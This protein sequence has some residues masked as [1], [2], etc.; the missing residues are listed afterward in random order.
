MKVCLALGGG[1][2][3]GYAH[4]GVLKG[5]FE[6]GITKF[7]AISGT[8]AGGMI[9]GLFA[10]HRDPDKIYEAILS[11]MKSPL[12][13]SL[14]FK[15]TYSERD[16]LKKIYGNI[17]E[18]VF[19]AKTLVSQSF[20]DEETQDK[21]YTHLYGKDTLL[22][23]YNQKLRI[24]ASD[25]VTGRD[26]AFQGGSMHKVMK[27]TSALPG[28]LP[29]VRLGD[30][31][32]VDGG[33]THNLPVIPLL[34]DDCDLIIASNVSRSLPNKKEYRN[35]A[36]ILIRCEYISLKRL[37]DIESQFADVVIAPD[38]SEYEWYDF[39][40]LDEILEQGYIAFKKMRSQ[41]EKVMNP[42]HRAK[43]HITSNKELIEKLTDHITY[44]P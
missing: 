31:L 37:E 34:K 42:I 7:H 25:L 12:S 26:L 15:E 29:P 39:D 21:I 23:Q 41:L 1:G 43:K 4:I 10:I 22:E 18:K 20:V 27:A 19:M 30:M 9:A 14:N 11:F 6:M 38:L 8:S 28:A 24:M 5:L 44:F 13:E 32:L 2:A 40:R 3:R 17:R 33:I 35:A 36:E 16:K